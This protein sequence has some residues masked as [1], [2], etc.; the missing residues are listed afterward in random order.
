MCSEIQVPQEVLLQPKSGKDMRITVHWQRFQ[1]DLIDGCANDDD[2]GGP[3]ICDGKLAGILN[4]HSSLEHSEVKL[5]CN[6]DDISFNGKS[7][8][9]WCDG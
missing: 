8:R 3:L 6:D 5:C 9:Q 2:D 4:F 7:E 1:I